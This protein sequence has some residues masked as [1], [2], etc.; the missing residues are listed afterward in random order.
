MSLA[1]PISKTAVD[2]GSRI[3]Q[4]EAGRCARLLFRLL[5]RAPSAHRDQHGRA[6]FRRGRCPWSAHR[7]VPRSAGRCGWS[8]VGGNARSRRASPHAGYLAAAAGIVLL[9]VAALGVV[10][11]LKDA[12]N[13]VW[14]VQ[15]PAE[16]GY[17]RYARTYPIARWH[18]GTRLPA[19]RV[20]DCQRRPSGL[21]QPHRRRLRSRRSAQFH[22]VVRGA[23]DP[24]SPCCSN[25]FRIPTWH[26]GTWCRA[27]SSPP[28]SSTSASPP[29]AGTSARRDSSSA[30][31]AAA[32]IVTLLVWV[33][34]SSQ[35]VLFGAELTHAYAVEAGSRRAAH[36]SAA[37]TTAA[38]A[39]A[40]HSP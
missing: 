1:H 23:G 4:R 33:Y 6:P 28:C 3:A 17:W 31:G 39:A 36:A 38:P 30:Y 19:R 18:I 14:N 27:P 8:S 15:D 40:A 34:Y 10:V 5:A 29:S 37:S 21:L 2:N 20:A 9:V 35:I 25:G 7:A 11:Q 24:V 13:T 12:M 32:S 22:R 26:G 16:A